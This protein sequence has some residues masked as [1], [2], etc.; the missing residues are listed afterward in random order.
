MAPPTGLVF[1]MQLTESPTVEPRDLILN[2]VM[3]STPII[4]LY[5]I[6]HLPPVVGTN[7]FDTFFFL[8]MLSSILVEVDIQY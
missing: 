5:I 8:F 1:Q 6:L 7:L 4:T 3:L 2:P